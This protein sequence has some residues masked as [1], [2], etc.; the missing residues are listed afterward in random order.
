MIRLKVL[1]PGDNRAKGFMLAAFHSP[2][3]NVLEPRQPFAVELQWQN[4][5]TGLWTAIDLVAEFDI[6]EYTT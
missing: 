5:H 3:G 2:D 4:K 1:K 6:D